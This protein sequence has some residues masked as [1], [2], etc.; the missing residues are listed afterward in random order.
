MHWDGLAIGDTRVVVES[1]CSSSDPIE[2]GP[3]KS[4]KS[5]HGQNIPTPSKG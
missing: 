2:S 1:K 4:G 3:V 5:N